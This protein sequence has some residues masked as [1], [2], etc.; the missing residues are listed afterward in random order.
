[1]SFDE[2]F[3]VAVAFFIFFGILFY[4][5]VPKKIGET[6]DARSQAIADELDA[7][8]KLREES[9]A[10]LAQ[11]QRKQREAE[12]EAQRPFKSK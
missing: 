12:Q 9:Q 5:K 8:R 2:T 7:A 11:Y 3:F 10:M 1:M 6:L 4:L